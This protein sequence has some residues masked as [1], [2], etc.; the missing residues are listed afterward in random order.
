VNNSMKDA[1]A[2]CTKTQERANDL[3]CPSWCAEPAGH[4]FVEPL[5]LGDIEREHRRSV[6]VVTANLGERTQVVINRLDLRDRHEPAH[7]S[8]DAHSGS[9]HLDCYPGEARA[10]AAALLQAADDLER[11]TPR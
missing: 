7:I 9:A 5:G 6:A 11:P 1:P 10:L 8:I 4:P 3:T 2:L